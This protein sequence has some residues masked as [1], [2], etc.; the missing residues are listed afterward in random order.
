MMSLF[1]PLA[2]AALACAALAVPS[3]P[4]DARAQGRP[5]FGIFRGPAPA[6][7]GPAPAFRGPAFGAPAVRPPGFYPGVPGYRA[8]YWGGGWGY[9]PSYYGWG[10]RGYPYWGWA[11]FGLGLGL[12]LA[13][14]WPWYAAPAY[15]TYPAYG[16]PPPYAQPAYPYGAAAP[17]YP[18]GM[19]TPGVPAGVPPA[20]ATAWPRRGANAA[21]CQAGPVT[22][23]LPSALGSGQPCSCPSPAGAV[24]GFA[25]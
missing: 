24:W 9:R 21:I 22:C 3:L 18:P 16:Y 1:R 2:M 25:Q 6:F 11:P 17:A 19:V 4:A 14:A 7:R 13:W 23:G 20:P 5:S 12:G 15:P 8:P 10:Y